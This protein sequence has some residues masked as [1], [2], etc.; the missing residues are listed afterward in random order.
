MAQRKRLPVH[1]GEILVEEFLKPL[2]FDAVPIGEGP[3]CPTAA[4]Q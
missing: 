2:S 4:N 3:K 1:P